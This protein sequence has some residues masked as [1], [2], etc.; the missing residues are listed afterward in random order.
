MLSSLSSPPHLFILYL[1][2]YRMNEA[3]NYFLPDCQII[4]GSIRVISLGF[5]PPIKIRCHHRHSQ[6]VA[7][8]LLHKTLDLISEDLCKIRSLIRAK[9]SF[10]VIFCLGKKKK[11]LS[12]SEVL[13]IKRGGCLSWSTLCEFNTL[14]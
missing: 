4:C 9:S 11:I 14:A 1:F 13:Q 10:P 12:Q 8:G 5:F 2:I 3:N 6:F 7:P